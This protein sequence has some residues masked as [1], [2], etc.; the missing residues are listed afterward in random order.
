MTD[1]ETL[2]LRV[3]AIAGKR[4]AD[5]FT[6]IWRELPIGRVMKASGVPAHL[7]QWS[8]SC[9]VHGKPVP[10]PTATATTSKTARRSSRLHGQ[11]YAPG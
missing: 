6:V 11:R 3:T 4:F 10:V 9:S 7:A 5:D 2:T 8:W 1:D